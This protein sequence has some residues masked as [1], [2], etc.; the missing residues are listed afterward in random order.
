MGNHGPSKAGHLN[1]VDVK[2]IH[3]TTLFSIEKIVAKHGLSELQLS[4]IGGWHKLRQR[5]EDIRAHSDYFLA[6]KQADELIKDV[7]KFVKDKR[8]KTYGN[9]S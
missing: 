6:L 1:A 9:I 2:Q 8:R 5:L 4:R 3:K 7:T